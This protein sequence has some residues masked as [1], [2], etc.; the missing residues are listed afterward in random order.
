LK[1]NPPKGKRPTLLCI[2]ISRKAVFLQGR[3]GGKRSDLKIVPQGKGKIKFL[4]EGRGRKGVEID[5][6]EGPTADHLN[7]NQCPAHFES[8]ARKGK[9]K[10]LDSAKPQ[11]GKR[12]SLCRGGGT[13]KCIEAVLRRKGRGSQNSLKSEKEGPS[14]SKEFG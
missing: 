7:G 12:F 6:T 3:K 10:I 14:Y 8:R 2:M 4:T 11:G 13:G 5:G 1:K 9:R